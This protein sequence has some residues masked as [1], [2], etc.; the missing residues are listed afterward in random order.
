MDSTDLAVL[1]T[2]IGW[3]ESGHQVMLATVVQTWGSAPRP[4]GAWLA[5]RDDGQL[6]GSVSG[7]CVEDDLIEQ[8]RADLPVATLPQIVRYG[9]SRDEAARFGLP[10]GGTL[11]LVL[12]PRPDLALLAALLARIR[13]KQ[14]TARVLDLQTGIAT[15]A[16]AGRS[17]VLQFDERFLRAIHGPRWRMV[18]IGAGELSQHVAQMA[19]GADYEVIVI[20]PREE[21]GTAL[22]SADVTLSRGMPDDVILELAVD[23]HTAIVALTH[24]PKLDDLA[25]ME[26]LKSAAFYVGALGSRANTARRRERLLEFDLTA[27]QIDRLHGPVGLY[28]GANTPAEMAISILAEITAVRHQVPVLQKREIPDGQRHQRMLAIDVVTA[29]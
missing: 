18:L 12:E 7:G 29:Y 27:Q 25:L 5:I 3:L 6:V 26:G 20:D 14:I 10:C 24:D 21:F 2:C 1:T 19:L 9:V 22:T 11:R 28:L 4:V 13:A 15:L 8:V 23:S 16:A 17:D